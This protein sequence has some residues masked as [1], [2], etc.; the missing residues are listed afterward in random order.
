VNKGN[1]LNAEVSAPTL[2]IPHIERIVRGVQIHVSFE[3]Q[4]FTILCDPPVW[5]T[6]VENF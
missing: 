4:D 6:K 5:F 1:A 3:L 2:M